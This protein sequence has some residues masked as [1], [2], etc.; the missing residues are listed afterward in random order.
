MNLNFPTVLV[1][2]FKPIEI[3]EVRKNVTLVGI[4]EVVLILNNV[5]N[6]EILMVNF[7]QEINKIINIQVIVA[8]KNFFEV[9]NITLYLV[10]FIND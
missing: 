9:V 2:L 3:I 7:V 5:I 8:K 1:T 10:I 4:E 6:K